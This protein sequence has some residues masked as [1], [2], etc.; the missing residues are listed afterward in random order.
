[1][2][3]SRSVVSHSSATWIYRPWYSPGLNT[4]VD[5]FSLLQGIFPTQG[6]NPG[7]RHC[8]GIIYRLSY[9]G[10]PTQLIHNTKVECRLISLWCL[11]IFLGY[12]LT[13]MCKTSLAWERIL[14]VCMRGR[15]ENDY[16]TDLY[17]SAYNL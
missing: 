1:M 16:N 17:V 10:S 3:E 15:G 7:L 4:G 14:I 5:S 12:F 8:R 2:S 11:F 9:Q 6:F 13:N